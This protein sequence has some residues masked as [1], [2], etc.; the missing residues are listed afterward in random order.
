MS[1]IIIMFIASKVDLQGSYIHMAP[2]EAPTSNLAD[3]V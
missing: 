1:F 3:A 2:E